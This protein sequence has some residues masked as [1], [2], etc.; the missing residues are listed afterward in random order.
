MQ[1]KVKGSEE[2]YKRMYASEME[3]LRESFEEEFNTDETA[4]LKPRSKH[5]RIHHSPKSATAESRLAQRAA[6]VQTHR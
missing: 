5:H 3:E 2:L 4:H 1:V 6:G